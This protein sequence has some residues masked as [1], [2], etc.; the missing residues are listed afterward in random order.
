MSTV[1]IGIGSN[2]GD[3]L[4][5]LDTAVNAVSLLPMTSRVACSRIYETAPVGYLDQPYFLNLVLK[6]ETTLS[7]QAMLGCCLG[8]EAAMGRVRNIKDGP[9]VIDLDLLVYNGYSCCTQEL[10]LPHPRILERAFVLVPL[11]D[12]YPARNVPMVKMPSKI[13]NDGIQLYTFV[14]NR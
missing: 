13:P 3:R 2:M 4:N 5:N 9:R 11:L 8:I 7:P 12:L 10:T 6:A 14:S 1:L